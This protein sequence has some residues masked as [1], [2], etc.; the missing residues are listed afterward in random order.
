MAIDGASID[1]VSRTFVEYRAIMREPKLKIHKPSD[2]SFSAPLVKYDKKGGEK[3]AITLNV[4]LLAAC[5]QSVSG[6]RM[7]IACAQ[8]GL[9]SATFQS[10]PIESQTNMIRDIKRAKAGFQMDVVSIKPEASVGKARE[11][12]EKRG[13]SNIAVTEGGI[14]NGKLLGFISENAIRHLGNE[15]SVEDVMR[16]FVH[17]SL[18]VLV[19]GMVGDGA[20]PQE[21]IKTVR[22]HL[23]YGKRGISLEDANKLLLDNGCKFVPIVDNK[24]NLYAVVFD[25]DLKAHQEH[26]HELIDTEKRLMAAA[27]INTHDY[28]TRVPEY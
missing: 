11:L 10:Q 5:M 27:G 12:I 2:V 17:H 22:R 21:V 18:E 14:P 26:P 3:P 15:R 4:A 20:T 9:L 19:T 8:E 25:K 6:T 7:G 16:P 24:K 28:E 13:Y 1:G 23:P